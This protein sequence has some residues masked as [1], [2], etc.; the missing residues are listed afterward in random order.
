MGELVVITG[1][2]GFIGSHLVEGFVRHGYAVRA[3]DNLSTGSLTNLAGLKGNIEYRNLDIRDLGSLTDALRDASIVLHHAGIS[4]VPRSFADRQYTHEVNVTG[5]LNVLLAAHLAGVR[6]VINA[7]SSSVYGNNGEEL[8]RES[9]TPVPL[10]PYGLSKWVSELYAAQFAGTAPI[11]TVSFQ[12]F[13]S[14][15]EPGKRLCRSHSV[16][17]SEIR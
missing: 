15:P 1:G 5:T 6:K 12:C 11:G 13:R 17:H 10:S 8:Q 7:S 3:I 9:A 14:A 16:V 4:S 2:A